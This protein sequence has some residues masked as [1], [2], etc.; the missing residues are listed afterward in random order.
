MPVLCNTM[1]HSESEHNCAIVK[2]TGFM[3][4]SAGN[5][6]QDSGTSTPALHCDAP[7]QG[8]TCCSKAW[9]LHLEHSFISSGSV[10]Q[11]EERHDMAVLRLPFTCR[12]ECTRQQAK[13]GDHS[14]RNLWQNETNVEFCKGARHSDLVSV[15]QHT[16]VGQQWQGFL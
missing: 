4:D 11:W 9:H 1:N 14:L 7:G 12:A 6:S 3:R 5:G 15:W 16:L 8:N 13:H 10:R 2:Q